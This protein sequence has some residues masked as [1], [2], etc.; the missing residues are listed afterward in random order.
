MCNVAAKTFHYCLGARMR[1][2][3]QPARASS[4]STS[5]RLSSVQNNTK[6]KTKQITVIT[7]TR[8]CSISNW[9]PAFT[10]NVYSKTEDQ[11]DVSDLWNSEASPR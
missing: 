4:F 5:S 6:I 8:M 10:S 11:C 9:S 3:A 7:R 2:N 1:L